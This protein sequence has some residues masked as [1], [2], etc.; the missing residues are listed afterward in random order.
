MPDAIFA[1]PRLADVYDVFDAERGDLDA[2][3]AIADEL[4]ASVVLDVGCG[5][6]TLAIRLAG[7]GRMVV[8]VDPA[9]ASL[10]VAKGK[11]PDRPGLEFV[12]VA[13]RMA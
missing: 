7:S 1:H 5:T 13:E 4:G 6:G 11:S 2:Y 12:F 10:D 9:E 8:G 3:V